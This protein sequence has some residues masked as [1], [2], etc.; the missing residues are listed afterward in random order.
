AGPDRNGE[1]QGIDRSS[2]RRR[3]GR[4]ARER[5]VPPTR[6]ISHRGL[7]RRRCG[8]PREARR[9]LQG[10]LMERAADSIDALTERM[11]GGDRVALARLITIVEYRG[12]ETRRVMSAA[13]ERAG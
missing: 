3:A 13:Y 8:V 7:Q 2:A 1:D 6:H 11:L 10:P 4:G 5:A 12:P 9:D